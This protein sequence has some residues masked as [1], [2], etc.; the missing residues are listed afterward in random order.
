MCVKPPGKRLHRL[1]VQAL[2]E[3]PH[4][5]VGEEVTALMEVIRVQSE[6]ESFQLSP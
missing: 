3:A 1:D 4:I 2:A 5:N 6:H